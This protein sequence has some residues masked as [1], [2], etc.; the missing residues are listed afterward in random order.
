MYC[1]CYI[2]I[3]FVKFVTLKGGTVLIIIINNLRTFFVIE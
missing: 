3:L 1:I 2:R